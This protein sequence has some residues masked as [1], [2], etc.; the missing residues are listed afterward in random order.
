MRGGENYHTVLH[1]VGSNY[2]SLHRAL[3]ARIVKQR[4]GG[5]G[6]HATNPRN[7]P[8]SLLHASRVL[9][10][11]EACVRDTVGYSVA[12]HCYAFVV[13]RASTVSHR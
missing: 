6:L 5:H 9:Y 12:T 3:D 1:R 10:Q 4:H 7:E 8:I 13:P 11:Q 2:C